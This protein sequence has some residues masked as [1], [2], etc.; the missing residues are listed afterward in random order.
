MNILLILLILSVGILI[1]GFIGFC[2][3]ISMANKL[4]KENH[5]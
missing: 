2:M 3:A 1:L 4:I 5:K